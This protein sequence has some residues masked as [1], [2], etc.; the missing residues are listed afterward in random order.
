MA[1]T[2]LPPEMTEEKL[3]LDCFE[4]ARYLIASFSGWKDAARKL[5]THKDMAMNAITHFVQ[6]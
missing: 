5:A 6:R 3:M 2:F 4:I 1:L